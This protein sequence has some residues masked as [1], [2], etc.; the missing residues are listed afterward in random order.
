MGHPGSLYFGGVFCSIIALTYSVKNVVFL[1][2]CRFFMVHRSLITLAYD[3]TCL[4]TCNNDRLTLNSLRCSRISLWLSDNFFALRAWGNGTCTLSFFSISYG[5]AFS[6]VLEVAVV[7]FGRLGR[8][9]PSRILP[10]RVVA[11]VIAF[12]P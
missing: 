10:L 2:W 8:P 7:L 11:V 9:G 6:K 12:T 5:G 1:T 3:G 4:I